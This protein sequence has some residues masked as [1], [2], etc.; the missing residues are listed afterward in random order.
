MNGIQDCQKSEF[1]PI[2]N[3]PIGIVK[4]KT[5]EY[6]AWIRMKDRCNNLSKIYYGGKGIKVCDRWV[7]DY[8]AFLADMGKM[9]S[10]K[11]TLDRIDSDKDY[12]PENCRWATMKEQG[13]N[14]GNNVVIEAFG[15]KK[16][17]AQWC[18]IYGQHGCTVS[19]RIFILGWDVEKALTDDASLLR[20]NKNALKFCGHAD[21]RKCV[22]C[23]Q[24]SPI[25]DLI[26][27]DPHWPAHH[28]ECGNL[29]N[30]NYRRKRKAEQP[31]DINLLRKTNTSGVTGVSWHK[32]IKRYVA[33]IVV[34]GEGKYIGCFEFLEDAAKARREAE[35]KYWG[36]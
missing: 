23:N 9:P 16:T 34:K 30:R 18:E 17:I 35:I 20:P 4:S 3:Q 36:K 15:E 11:H 28:R 22:Y 13:N 25:E 14:R 24:Y 32:K 19:R 29:Y 6:K 1:A 12:S 2:A 31:K 26:I 21:W 7:H 8:S 27:G 10:P 33:R 5:K